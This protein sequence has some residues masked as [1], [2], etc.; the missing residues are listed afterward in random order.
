MSVALCGAWVL[1]AEGRAGEARAAA[2]LATDMAERDRLP[3]WLLRA[4]EAVDEPATLAGRAAIAASLG[5]P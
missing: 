1:A 4:L 3:W 5:L 2:R